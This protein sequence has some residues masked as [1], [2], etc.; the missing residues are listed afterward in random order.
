MAFCL[1]G[2]N[3]TECI[4][5]SEKKKKHWKWPAKWIT[6]VQKSSKNKA[7]NLFKH[8]PRESL[9]LNRHSACLWKLMDIR[10]HI[11]KVIYL[12]YWKTT[13]PHSL[14]PR[15]THSKIF[16]SWTVPV[17][18]AASTFWH[19]RQISSLSWL[20]MPDHSA[21][22][23]GAVADPSED[24][25]PTHSFNS[26]LFLIISWSS[27]LQGRWPRPQSKQGW[28]FL[29]VWCHKS[30]TGS[31]WAF[32]IQVLIHSVLKIGSL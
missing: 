15:L 20:E 11:S 1:S 3:W 7:M 21:I 6:G 13:L 25:T 2:L 19:G 24:A 12:Q 28:Q 16:T 4:F 14:K 27:K 29:Q 23:T 22:A 8:M 31:L 26:W 10:A 30:H 32:W 17:L 5:L 18:F 9:L